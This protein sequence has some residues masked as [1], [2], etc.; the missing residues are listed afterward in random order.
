MADL[1]FF[2]AM[3]ITQRQVKYQVLRRQ[4]YGN[5]QR[6]S[7]RK[8]KQPAMDCFSKRTITLFFNGDALLDL[9]G[10]RLVV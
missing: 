6:I 1:L 4:L 5:N 9:F 8:K 3:V 10:H 2:P 7:T